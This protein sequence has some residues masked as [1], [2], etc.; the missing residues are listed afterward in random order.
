[1]W[2]FCITYQ[3]PVG[4][5]GPETPAKVDYKT[6]LDERTFALFSKLRELRKALAEKENLPPYAVFTNEQL[7][8]VAKV[9]CTTPGELGKIDGIG[10]ARIEKYGAALVAAVTDY[11]KQQSAVGAD[12]GAGKPA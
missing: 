2:S 7:A 9:R 5:G 6:V 12:R 4:S 11:D 3:L 10:P 1:V 8:E